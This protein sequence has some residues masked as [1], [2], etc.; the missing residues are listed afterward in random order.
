MVITGAGRESGG[1]RWKASMR[2]QTHTSNG[3]IPRPLAQALK[4]G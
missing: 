2:R 1:D 4:L 3:A